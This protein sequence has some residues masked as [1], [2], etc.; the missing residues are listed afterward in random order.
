MSATVPYLPSWSPL[1]RHSRSEREGKKKTRSSI[2]K[3]VL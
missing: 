2:E 1:S 3:R